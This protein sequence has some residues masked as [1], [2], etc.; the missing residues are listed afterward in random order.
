MCCSDSDSDWEE[1]LEDGAA[2][3]ILLNV[4]KQRET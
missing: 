1:E 3:F 2:A 4:A